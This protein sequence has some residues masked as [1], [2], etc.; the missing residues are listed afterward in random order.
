MG[1]SKSSSGA[2]GNTALLPPWVPALP[3]TPLTENP[4]NTSSSNEQ[5]TSPS[6]CAPKPLQLPDIPRHS[7]IAPK[8]RFRSAHISLGKYAKEGHFSQLRKGVGQYIKGL[9]GKRIATNRVAGSILTAEALNSALLNLSTGQNFKKN[10]PI[11]FCN[12]K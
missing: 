10:T 8:A 2:P 12:D 9:G 11:I 6:I 4:E 1:T 3:D 7:P 5:E